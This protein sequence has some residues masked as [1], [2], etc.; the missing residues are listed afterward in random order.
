VPGEDVT[1]LRVGYD[2]VANR[3][4]NANVVAELAKKVMSVRR[5]LVGEQPLLSGLA[6][7]DLDADAFLPVH[8]GAAAFFNGTQESFIDRYSNV[9][10]LTPMVLGALASIFAAAWR[11]LG[12]HP[13]RTAATVLQVLYSMP[14]RIRQA[15][16]DTALSAIEAEIDS[17]LGTR[18]ASIAGDEDRAAE[19]AM[20][21]SAAGR[22]DHLIYHRRMIL[23]STTA[24]DPEIGLAEI[25]G[26]VVTQARAGQSRAAR[27][28][29]TLTAAAKRP[30]EAK[31]AAS[32]M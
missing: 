12:V 18:L 29:E 4:L 11:F 8:P 22:L 19:T 14:A 9:I 21:I 26:R 13:D 10:Y 24:A 16:D 31:D 27:P 32:Q 17:P 23:A 6:A 3:Q 7:P 1:T 15:P 20:L 28:A 5:D 2:L 25:F 30:D